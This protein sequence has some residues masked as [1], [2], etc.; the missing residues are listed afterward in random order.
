MYAWIAV[1]LLPT[2]LCPDRRINN[3]RHLVSIGKF[4]QATSQQQ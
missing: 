1:F 2:R 4:Q 3:C